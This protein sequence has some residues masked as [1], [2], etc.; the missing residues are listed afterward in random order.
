MNLIISAVFP[1]EPV[2]SAKLSYDIAD[3]IGEKAPVTVIS[4]KPSRPFGFMFDLPGPA[5]HFNH[6]VAN[7]FISPGSNVWG[8]FFESYSFGKYCYQYIAANQAAIKIIYA[9]TWPLLAQYY[10]VLACKKFNIPVVMHVQDVYPESLTNK[11]PLIRRLLNYLLLPID[12]FVLRHATKI[13]AI[14]DQM[15][16]YL[17]ETRKIDQR[18]IFVVRNWQD[19]NSFMS[20][21]KSAP[22]TKKNENP[23]TF[24]YLGNMGVASGVDLLLDAFAA[25]Q[26]ANCRLIIAGSGSQKELLEKKAAGMVDVHIEFRQVPDGK[27][28]EMQD[29]ADVLLLPLKRGAAKSSIPSKLAAYM[30]SGKPVI[31]CVDESSDTAA[32]IKDSGCGYVVEPENINQLSACMKE[33]VNLPKEK[34]EKMGGN[35]FAFSVKNLSKAANLE[36]VVSIILQNV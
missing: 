23:F 1:P 16:Q 14:S 25:A 32:C 5:G 21:R 2:V 11:F 27:V 34:L 3:A 30:F 6:V 29:E 9:N 19:E 28:P 15:K 36:K 17:A 35:G 24:M 33:M 12:R 13:I 4:P 8:R 22:V 31:G 7:S 20:F 18:K 10:T 26:P